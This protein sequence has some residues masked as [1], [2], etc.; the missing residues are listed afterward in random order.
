MP[1]FPS[2]RRLSRC[3]GLIPI[4]AFLLLAG[5]DEETTSIKTLLDDPARF[6]E[7]TVR[8]AGEVKD[9]AGALGIGTYEV[10][11]GTG[12]IRVVTKSGGAPR[13]GARV[14]VEGTFHSAYTVGDDTMAVINEKQRYEP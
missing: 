6:N 8:I 5:C 7:K 1:S 13:E 14:G 2:V 9:S 3:L 11:D 12:N 10:D 4:G